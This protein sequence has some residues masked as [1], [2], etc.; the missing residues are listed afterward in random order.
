MDWFLDLLKAN[1]GKTPEETLESFK[2][3]FPKHAVPK[4]QYNKVA[5]EK[6]DL[7]TENQTLTATMTEL[8]KSAGLTEE[9]KVKLEATQT[10]LETFKADTDK[11]VLSEQK[12][13]HLVKMLSG[14]TAPDLIELAIGK[15]DLDK[16][17]LTGDKVDGF[18]TQLEEIKKSVPSLFVETTV[19]APAPAK[20]NKPTPQNNTW[21]LPKQYRKG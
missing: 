1:E 4:E 14:K 9:M 16:I 11:R 13:T 5:T 6:K 10:E 17:I 8:Q 20:G 3:E 7:A 18:E 21:F 19:E 2:G 12:K 15:F